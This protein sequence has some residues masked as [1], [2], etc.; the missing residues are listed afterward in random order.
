VTIGLLGAFYLF[1]G[2]YGVLGRVAAPELHLAGAT[3]T[4]VVTLP[5]HL[6]AGTGASLVR[7]LVVTGAFAAFLST[8]SGLLLS[9]A[10]ALS[11]DLTRGGVR[12]LREAAAGVALVAVLLALPSAHLD[13]GVLVGWA[14]AVAAS[15]LCPLPV[16]GIWWPQLTAPGAAAGL[17]C[18]AVLSTG[19]VLVTVLAP[20][21]PGWL[22]TLLGQPAG[23]SVPAGTTAALARMHLVA[24]DEP[25]GGRASPTGPGGSSYLPKSS[26][27][28]MSAPPRSL[29]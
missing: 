29:L 21:G 1:P 23:W 27:C 22:A 24:E 15:T 6:L 5:A 10:S 9:L 17:V 28:G 12:G 16:L 2:V 19:A 14:F 26:G 18:G 25:A 7:A 11:H 20:P 3:D 4:V 13:I 8:S